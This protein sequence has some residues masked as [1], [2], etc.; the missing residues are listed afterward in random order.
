MGILILFQ[1]L[2]ARLSAFH[3]G[4]IINSFFYVERDSL[5]TTLVRMFIMSGLSSAFSVYI[6]MIMWFFSIV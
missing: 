5:C 2:V 1:I 4:F 3:C 6:E